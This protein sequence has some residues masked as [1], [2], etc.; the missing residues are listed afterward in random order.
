MNC[1]QNYDI[2][3]VNINWSR[4]S[5]I[6]EKKEKKKSLNYAICFGSKLQT[7]KLSLS[8]RAWRRVF[9]QNSLLS[10]VSLSS[11]WSSLMSSVECAP[12]FYS[13]QQHTPRGVE[14]VLPFYAACTMCFRLMLTHPPPVHETRRRREKTRG[15]TICWRPKYSS[16][17]SSVLVSSSSSSARLLLLSSSLICSVIMPNLYLRSHHS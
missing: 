11:W 17:P 10:S 1:E 14:C 12:F 5:F 13:N 7:L 15:A 16:V 6:R 9:A 8:I 3:N 4:F 2:K